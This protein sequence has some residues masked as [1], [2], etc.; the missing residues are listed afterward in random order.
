MDRVA[1]AL[2]LPSWFGRN[3]DAL[4]DA[5]SD[6]GQVGGERVLLVTGWQDFAEREPGQWR[7]A[8]EVFERATAVDVRVSLGGS[9]NEQG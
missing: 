5:L 8:R 3:W 7:V 4:A 9:S 6:P 1:V 2:A